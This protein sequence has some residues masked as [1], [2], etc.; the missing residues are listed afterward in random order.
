[1]C[2]VPG[3]RYAFPEVHEIALLG[4]GT[5]MPLL[6]TSSH[7]CESAEKGSSPVHEIGPRDFCVSLDLSSRLDTSRA[8][9]VLT[10]HSSSNK[11]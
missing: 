4:L 10:S 9:D 6:D 1:M 5:R 3:A 8:Q 2:G 11:V 7:K